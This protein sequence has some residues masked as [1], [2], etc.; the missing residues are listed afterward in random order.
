MERVLAGRVVEAGLHG[1]AVSQRAAAGQHPGRRR[2]LVRREEVVVAHGLGQRVAVV[3]CVCVAVDGQHVGRLVAAQAGRGRGRRGLAQGQRG[4]G[5]AQHQGRAAG[6]RAS[7]LGRGGGQDDGLAA[8]LLEEGRG[9]GLQNEF[10]ALNALVL[11]TLR[12]EG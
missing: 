11:V 12:G 5:A 8:L 7:V 3:V 10:G 1:V 2:H 9:G 4:A 6:E